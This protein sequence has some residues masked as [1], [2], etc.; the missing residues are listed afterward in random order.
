M[1]MPSAMSA[2]PDPE[3]PRIPAGREALLARIAG[4]PQAA[5]IP[6]DRRRDWLDRVLA[7]DAERAAWHVAR[8]GGF[9]GS[10]AHIL[11]AWGGW[12]AEE[13]GPRWG[14]PE[15]LVRQKLLMMAPEPPG[16]DAARGLALEPVIRGLFEE[17]M[18][19]E[20]TWRH[21]DDLKAL[22]DA[23]AHPGMPWLRASIDA[24]YDI[25]GEIWIIDFKAPSEASLERQRERPAPAYAAQLNHYALLAEGLGVRVGGLGVALLDYRY[26]A[27]APVLFHEVGASPELRRAISVGGEALWNDFVMR[28]R[29]PTPSG[30]NL[31]ATPGT[32]GKA[33]A[34]SPELVDMARS[35]WRIERVK[36]RIASDERDLRTRLVAEMRRLG[37]RSARVPDGDKAGEL[38]LTLARTFDAEAA[39]E[40]ARPWLQGGEGPGEEAFRLPEFAEPAAAAR[41][42]L[43]LREMIEAELAL[44][45]SSPEGACDALRRVRDALPALKPGRL[46]AA[47]LRS[48]LVEE[49]GE[50]EDAFE[51]ARLTIGA[52]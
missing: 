37:L 4:L 43:E 39:L 52:R 14:S 22:L 21:R 24:V 3:D 16:V 15:R 30:A 31:Q 18:L 32:G 38:R 8:A 46:D 17:N 47:R 19:A 12:E 2:L 29:V 9:G 26:F 44:A 34:P 1:T 42:V 35:L 11:A 6:D 13:E 23:H 5:V 28:G 49:L 40:R 10:E 41:R 27:R 33:Q 50:S 51:G 20:R 45:E 25:D 48:F 7:A 36:A